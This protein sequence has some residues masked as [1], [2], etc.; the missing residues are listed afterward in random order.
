MPRTIFYAWQSDTDPA[1]NHFFI[2]E[3]LKGAIAAINSELQLQ[4][5]ESQV[6]FD[7]DTHGEPGMPPV[8]DTILKKID[9]ATAFVADLTLVTTLEAK[10]KGLPNANV[11][12]ELGYAAKA[13]GFQRIV[14]AINTYYGPP[15]KLPFD[16]VHRL[17]PVEFRLVPDA[18]QSQKATALSDLTAQFTKKLRTIIGTVGFSTSVADPL[19]PHAQRSV[20][21]G[22]FVA[23]GPIARA[24]S[25]DAEGRN[26]EHVFWHHNPSASLRLIPNMP[27]S[28][29]RSRLAR[30]AAGAVP[31]LH[32]FGDSGRQEIIANHHGAVAIGYED[33][34]PDIAMQI[35]QVFPTG[36]IW[37]ISRKLIEPISTKPARTLRI[38][39]PETLL[40][41]ERTLAHYM[42]FAQHALAHEL[43]V[44]I[45]AGL[46]MVNDMQMIFDKSKW[47]ADA[48]KAHWFLE[49]SISS[50]AVISE[51][52]AAP[53]AVLTPFFRR[54]FEACAASYDDWRREK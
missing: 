10:D 13:L 37:G 38:P 35:T 53:E 6:I 2:G 40:V 44:T 42:Y 21:A 33:Y 34:L 4:E 26:N 17:F 12:I 52:D 23:E 25:R 32:A 15:S 9:G 45:V 29:T 48:P 14:G 50:V 51:W 1:V 41:F 30:L 54:M 11:G 16:L 36:E 46:E 19:P 7:R 8:A 5:S 20:N 24:N 31:P 43:P 39:W 27:K 18:D 22:S 28:F 3:A 47:Y 49:S